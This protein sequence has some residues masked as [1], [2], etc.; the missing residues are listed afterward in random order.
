M[1]LQRRNDVYD[2]RNYQHLEDYPIGKDIRKKLMASDA[3]YTKF[4]YPPRYAPTNY[5]V[6][7]PNSRGY[8]RYS[9]LPTRRR[10]YEEEVLVSYLGQLWKSIMPDIEGDV[11]K[12]FVLGVMK[13]ASDREKIV[14]EIKN[15]Y[16]DFEPD[17]HKT[18]LLK[19]SILKENK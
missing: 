4:I 15:Y 9:Y 2:R 12:E 17:N 5:F 8:H 1:N 13:K 18:F 14:S 6:W 11:G 7:R 10:A 16:S 19:C 3:G